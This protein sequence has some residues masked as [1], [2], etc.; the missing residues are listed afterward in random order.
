[1]LVGAFER[2]NFGDLL[3][4]RL[5]EHRLRAAGVTTLAAA[6]SAADMS[7]TLGRFVP[8]F[9][10][11]LSRHAFDVVWSVGGELGGVDQESAYRF[12]LTEDEFRI[13]REAGD[14]GRTAITQV[15]SGGDL[16]G[17]AYLPDLDGWVAQ[18]R[19]RSVLHSVGLA[20]AAALDE[21]GLA[22]FRSAVVR[23]DAITVRDRASSR[24]LDE[25][26]QPH[27]LAPDVVH[28][29][30]SL[31]PA[32]HAAE[33]KVLVQI[34]ERALDA[35]TEHAFIEALL[36]TEA[37]APFEIAF[38]AAGIAPGHDSLARYE[39][40]ADELRRA[41]R[42]RVRVITGR[43]PEVLVAEIASAALWIGTSLHGR[44]VSAAFRVPRIGL[45][46]AKLDGYAAEWDPAMPF[47]VEPAALPSAARTALADDTR[48]R[49]D[50]TSAA[51][52]LTAERA[53]RE[54][55]EQ[56]VEWTS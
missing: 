2:D 7:G 8:A 45:S 12:S 26:E 33:P 32:E 37:I 16:T 30:R 3:F 15:L 42:A 5:T 23:A 28:A 54:Q 43:E 47:G 38:F 31:V 20:G 25:L 1:M 24:L 27:R 6:P 49:A 44:V 41:G 4:L 17:P 14:A 52:E 50:E 10:P 34:S 51:L 22:A 46:T 35:H 48:T 36:A 9:P 29:I 53:L 13:Y 40:M 55:I 21:T 19:A 56:V 11:L 39:V 18:E